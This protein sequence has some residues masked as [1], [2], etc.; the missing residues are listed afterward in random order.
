MTASA[1]PV[2]LSRADIMVI[3]DS[4]FFRHLLAE[5]LVGLGARKVREVD[6]AEEALCQI[7]QRP[8]TLI[9]CDW[10]MAPIDGLEFLKRLRAGK[11]AHIPVIMITGNATTQHV[12]TA[13]H[14][15]AASYIVKPFKAATLLGHL[16]KVLSGPKDH[17]LLEL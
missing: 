6:S 16:A 5:L 4:K 10:M 13:L 17:Q 11:N 7:E 2:D 9:F 14:D 3:D 15:G 8:P 1:L 12:S